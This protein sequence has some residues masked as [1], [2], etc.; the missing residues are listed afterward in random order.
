[1]NFLADDANWYDLTLVIDQGVTYQIAPGSVGDLPG[2]I[3]LRADN[4]SNYRL[5]VIID[6]GPKLAAEQ[7][8]TAEAASELVLPISAEQ[9]G[10][11]VLIESEGGVIG[12]EI[13]AAE[14]PEPEPEPEPT[15]RRR[16][17]GIFF[18]LVQEP[19]HAP[20]L[21]KTISFLG[22]VRVNDRA[23]APSL[24]AR[25]VFNAPLVRLSPKVLIVER[26]I[27]ESRNPAGYQPS[28]LNLGRVK[29]AP[30]FPIKPPTLRTRSALGQVR[31]PTYRDDSAAL[32]AWLALE[33]V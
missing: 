28:T 8:P 18:Q 27:V 5:K 29:V 10:E 12:F 32:A 31:I 7:T 14:E 17:G 20:Q 21:P 6:Q 2:Y 23:T 3:V 19:V 30:S 24:L 11:I 22:S 26:R 4:G 16:G 9:W 33:L 13:I 1:M 25:T 15:P